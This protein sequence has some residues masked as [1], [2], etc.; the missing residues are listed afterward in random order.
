MALLRRAACAA[1]ALLIA[2][3]ALFAQTAPSRITGRVT[4]AAGIALAGAKIS[5]KDASGKTLAS[6]LTDQQ[7]QYSLPL[8]DGSSTWLEAECAGYQAAVQTQIQASGGAAAQVNFRLKPSAGGASTSLGAVSFYETPAFQTGRLTDPSAGGGYSDQAS[9]VEGKMIG[10]YLAPEHTSPPPSALSGG[11]LPDEQALEREGSVL[12]RSHNYTRATPF[13]REAG[14]RYPR[15]ARLAAGL[16]ISL[17]GQGQYSAAV[18]SLCR[19]ARLGPEEA[20]TYVFLAEAVQLM[21]QSNA[22]AERL[23]KS[24]ADQHPRNAGGHYAYALTLWRNF[25][26]KRDGASLAAAEAELKSAVQLDPSLALAHFQLGLV[27]DQE[28][29]TGRAIQE[30]RAA[31]RIDPNFTGVHYRLAQD[32]E[33]AG[34]KEEAE[35]EL[36][37]YMRLRAGAP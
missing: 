26:L 19:A 2:S 11:A 30:Y 13:Y 1:A 15:S 37:T 18:D 14:S 9:S 31:E 16:G 4:S 34:A 29:S 5:L 22:D 27:Y 36:K 8:L 25:R 7:G 28:R 21:P 12:L 3:A 32:E 24:F 33:R 10:Q 35:E 17:Y 6:S 20:S 23:V